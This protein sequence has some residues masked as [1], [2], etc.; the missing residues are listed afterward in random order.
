MPWARKAAC[1]AF[2]CENVE[3]DD[4]VAATNPG[5]QLG[6]HVCLSVSDTGNGMPSE[7]MEKIFDPFFT[8]KEQGKGTGLGLAT[9]LGI[10]KG[11]RGFITIQSQVGKGT[12]FKVFIPAN[13]D[14]Q[15][16]EQK[17]EAASIL[18]GNGELILVVDDEAPVREAIV[19]TLE[20][21]GYRCYTAE[22]GTDALALYFERRNQI[23]VVVTDLH[24]GVMDGV[25]LVRSIRKVS[26]DARIIVSSGHIHKENQAP[27]WAWASPRFWKS[28][29]PR[30]NCCARSESLLPLEP[31]QAA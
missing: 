25:T 11:H 30:R 5:A 17:Q 29:T 14:A 2:T 3:V 13:R 18:Q 28:P 1:C 24:M 10:V 27:S 22:D 19:S 15:T 23:S 7:V 31:A 20:A 6:P 12:T 8:T 16:Q 4:H 26:Q 9:V 21:N